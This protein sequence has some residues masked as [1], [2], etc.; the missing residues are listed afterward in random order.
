MDSRI[1]T[2]LPQNDKIIQLRTDLEE[3]KWHIT[4][5]LLWAMPIPNKGGDFTVVK[6]TRKKA[7]NFLDE[8]NKKERSK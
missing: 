2:T 1:D 4:R 5:L 3:A 8:L 7:H 6:T